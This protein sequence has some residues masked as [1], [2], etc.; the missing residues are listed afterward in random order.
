MGQNI[1]FYQYLI[2]VSMKNELP[3]GSEYDST[4]SFFDQSSECQQY[5]YD[6]MNN[7][8]AVIDS[9]VHGRPITET[10]RDTETNL[11][12]ILI[13]RYIFQQLSQISLVQSLFLI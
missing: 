6:L 11:T 1:S 7:N 5:F 10:W 8:I 4:K 12:L 2:I 13:V 3:N 9:D